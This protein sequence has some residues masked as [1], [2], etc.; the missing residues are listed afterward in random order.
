[1]MG[2]DLRHNQEVEYRIKYPSKKATIAG[3]I[4][5]LL[6][7]EAECEVRDYKMSRKVTTTEEE[8]EQAL[9]VHPKRHLS[10]YVNFS[11][12]NYVH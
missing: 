11:F 10:V 9:E 2:E 8:A 6:R 12:S 4:D 5:A 3:R 7:S 1:M